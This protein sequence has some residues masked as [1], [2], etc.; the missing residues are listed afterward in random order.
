MAA[1]S[2]GHSSESS[3][4]K[5]ANDDDSDVNG[6]CDNTITYVKGLDLETS[7]M[8]VSQAFPTFDFVI[9]SFIIPDLGNIEEEHVIAFFTFQLPPLV[10]YLP[11]LFQSFL[12]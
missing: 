4:H 12:L 5:Q 9:L 6:C 10:R 3:C 11:V 8:S 1:E 2:C 7:T